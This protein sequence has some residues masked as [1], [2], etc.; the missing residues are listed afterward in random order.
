MATLS[1]FLT[2]SSPPPHTHIYTQA[3]LHRRGSQVDTAIFARF[4]PMFSFIFALLT[5]LCYRVFSLLPALLDTRTHPHIHTHMRTHSHTG[6]L[7][8]QFPGT[9]PQS[10]A[11]CLGLV[12]STSRQNSAP[13]T[14]VSP[15][16]LFPIFLSSALDPP[17]HPTKTYKSGTCPNGLL[18][19][20]AS[21]SP[22]LFARM[23]SLALALRFLLSCT[24]VCLR[25]S[26]VSSFPYSQLLPIL[27][28]ALTCCWFYKPIQEI[29]N[30][31]II[32]TKFYVLYLKYKLR[33][34]WKQKTGQ[35]FLLGLWGKATGEELYV[36]RI[37]K[38]E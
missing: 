6:T 27:F 7:L 2:P 26:F 32:V 37:L 33:A 24:D 20:K 4:L 14:L 16:G 3:K 19:L 15:P 34:I 38:D 23:F 21:L 28:Q 35:S 31:L 12:Y 13:D 9:S 22:S 30:Q 18:Q 5:L 10:S 25:H 36:N 11:Q 29:D 1:P 17:K 8:A